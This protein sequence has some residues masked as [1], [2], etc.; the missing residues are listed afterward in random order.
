MNKKLFLISLV[1][2][3]SSFC[4]AEE[5]HD[6]VKA[7]NLPAVKK[8]LEEHG[9]DKIKLKKLINSEGILGNTPLH[10]ATIANNKEIAEILLRFGANINATNY[11]NSTLLHIA[12]S[13]GYLEIAEFFVKNGAKINIKDKY[14]KTPYDHAKTGTS[15][16]HKKIAQLLASNKYNFPFDKEEIYELAEKG[17]LP[18]IKKLLEKY[19]DDKKKLKELISSKNTAA[20][21]I[22]PL[23]IAAYK[24]YEE[25]VKFFLDNGA[26]INTKDI[27]SDTPLHDAT[28]AERLEIVKILVK[29]GA[30]LNAKDHLGFTPYD[31]AV[32][33]GNKQ[34]IKF[35][36]SKTSAS[37]CASVIKK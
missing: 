32:R 25:I 1:F 7:G 23:H 16:R 28:S 19:K 17:D 37:K 36:K 4:F 13:Q 18:A 6:L 34:M 5:I 27:F 11:R 24:G 30:N 12:A 9:N 26:K 8:I 10:Y 2:L 29:N 22:T 21:G 3:F 20:G 14:G 33:T 31:L 15:K 35:L